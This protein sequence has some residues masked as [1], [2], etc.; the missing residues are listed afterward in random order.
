MVWLGG[1]CIVSST[2]LLLPNENGVPVSSGKSEVF[3]PYQQWFARFFRPGNRLYC[4]LF[5]YT[6]V[7]RP[8]KPGLPGNEYVYTLSVLNGVPYAER[9]RFYN[10][11]RNRVA[12]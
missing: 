12:G 2:E 11:T 7:T 9:I 6:H 1:V 8:D 10:E 4:E 5:R 3:A